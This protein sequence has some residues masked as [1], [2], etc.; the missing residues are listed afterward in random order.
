MHKIAL[1]LSLATM[2][3]ASPV[4]AATYAKPPAPVAATAKPAAHTAA[5]PSHHKKKAQVCHYKGK[6]VACAKNKTH[7]HSKT[8]H[9]KTTKSGKKK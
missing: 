1:S 7:A 8:V 9:K 5:K 6:K 2:L 4:F 3:L